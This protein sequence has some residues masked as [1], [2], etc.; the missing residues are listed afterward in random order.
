MPIIDIE[1]LKQY[2]VDDDLY[3]LAINEPETVKRYINIIDQK[4]FTYIQ[5]DQFQQDNWS[6][7]YPDDLKMAA[8][9]LVQNMFIFQ[10]KWWNSLAAWNRTAKSESIGDYSYSESRSF[11]NTFVLKF[12]WIPVDE[13]TRD[14]LRKYGPEQIFMW[15]WEVNLT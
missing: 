13:Q 5:R 12:F 15:D 1:F 3:K 14:I 2:C 11:D 7:L 6:Y 9:M 10:I 4:I 8:V